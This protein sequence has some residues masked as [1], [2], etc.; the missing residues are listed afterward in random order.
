[1]TDQ[2]EAVPGV[3]AE[4]MRRVDQNPARRHT[5]LDGPLGS[6]NGLG[7]HIRDDVRI[8]HPE[9]P[10]TRYGPARVRTHQTGAELG[11][12]PGEFRIRTRPGVVDQ[13][14]PGFTGGASN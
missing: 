5:R 7:D 2:F 8:A 14:G 1:R 6:G 13:I 9:R 3:L 4:V 12:D 11:S 10:G